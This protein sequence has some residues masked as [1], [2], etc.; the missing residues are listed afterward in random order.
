MIRKK[1]QL[2]RLFFRLSH[3][4][5]SGNTVFYRVDFS[6]ATITTAENRAFDLMWISKHHE[7]VF[8]FPARLP[9]LVAKDVPPCKFLDYQRQLPVNFFADR[10]FVV[11][12]FVQSHE[13]AISKRRRSVPAY[14][15]GLLFLSRGLMIAKKL[16]LAFSLAALKFR[17]SLCDFSALFSRSFMRPCGSAISALISGYLHWRLHWLTPGQVGFLQC[18][19]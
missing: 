17:N 11:E 12:C 19:F 2:N 9:V 18:L 6:P 5:S 13:I 15:I 7:S 8:R 1:I 10:N 16:L 3:V 14:F 4:R